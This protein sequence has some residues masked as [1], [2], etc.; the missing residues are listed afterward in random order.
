[1]DKNERIIRTI[2]MD[3]LTVYCD[4]L[5]ENGWHSEYARL[6]NA[7][8]VMNPF[9]EE[10]GILDVYIEDLKRYKKLRIYS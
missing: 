4:L 2:D 8:T 5:K 9:F 7:M 6:S 3:K 10:T 1:M